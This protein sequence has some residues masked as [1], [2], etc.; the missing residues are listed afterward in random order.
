MKRL[1]SLFDYSGMWGS[2]FYEHGWDVI[3]WD[4]KTDELMD[5]NLFEEAGDVL[6]QFEDVDALL[7]APPCTDY[8]NSGAQYWPA[9]DISGQTEK[10]NEMIRQCLRLVD[11]FRPTD[12]D[13]DDVFF[14]ALEN[15][16]GRLNTVFP[17]LGKPMY[18]DPCDYA[19]YVPGI[20][21]DVI[22]KLDSIRTKNGIKVTDAENDFVVR[23]NAY[24]K[25]TGIWGE[26]NRNIPKKRIEPVKTS[27]QGTFTQ[28]Y[29]GKS[30]KTK[31]LRSNTPVGFSIAFYEANHNYRFNMFRD[32]ENQKKIKTLKTALKFCKSKPEM[33]KIKNEIKKLQQFA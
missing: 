20:N 23:Y 21:P 22:A 1:L 11:L 32:E 27:P 16:A 29:G 8:T 33:A 24:T 18:F 6:D 9:K 17:E 13:Y 15:P 5:I 31:E 14:W 12:P 19:G 25:R 7:M 26:F 28:R 2:E 10:S 30:A 4:I 3:P